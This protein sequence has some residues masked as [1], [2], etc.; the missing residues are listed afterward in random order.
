MWCWIQV[1]AM[2]HSKVN[3]VFA[4]QGGYSKELAFS[5][6]TVQN[7]QA[8]V[9]QVLGLLRLF[10]SMFKKPISINIFVYYFFE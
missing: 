4:D 8:R 5:K 9:K 6:P 2:L 3:V 7:I 1:N 10:V